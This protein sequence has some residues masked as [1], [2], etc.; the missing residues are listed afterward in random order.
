MAKIQLAFHNSSLN[1]DED[2]KVELTGML[3][4]ASDFIKSGKVK[5]AE[6]LS[7]FSK[8]LFTIFLSQTK[9]GQYIAINPFSNEVVKMQ[10][11]ELPSLS[12]LR[13]FTSI[14][15]NLDLN[16][17]HTKLMELKASQTDLIGAYTD[18]QMEMISKLLAAPRDNRSDFT[19]LVPLRG[20]GKIKADVKSVN[21]KI[22]DEASL[23]K[24]VTQRLDLIETALNDDSTQYT[25][26]LTERTDYWQLEIR[27]KNENLDKQ[28]RERD[29][30]LEQQLADLTGK[31]KAKSEDNFEKFLLGVAKNIRRDETP[32]EGTLQKIEKLTGRSAQPEDVP[33]IDR[34][35]QQLADQ[36]ETFKAAVLFAK[37]Q[38]KNMQSKEYDISEMQELNVEGLKKV[39]EREKNEYREKANMIEKE[40]DPELEQLKK[41]RDESS[42]RLSKFRDLRGQWASEMTNSLETKGKQMISSSSLGLPSP[43]PLVELQIPIYLFQYKKKDELYTVVVPPVNL[44]D[45]FKKADRSAFAGNKKTVFYYLVVE[46]TKKQIA[47]WFEDAASSR[48]LQT[49]IARLPNILDDPSEL[50]DTFFNSQT[51]MTDKLK[52]NKK[53]I[54]KANERLTEVLTSG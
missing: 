15:K 49:I 35:L 17:L 26:K 12:D 50:R 7:R 27:N 11:M 53:D 14:H 10:I 18:K 40:R 47:N 51:L 25:N 48:D 16:R 38:V 42:D 23:K 28:L 36:A 41:E 4:L 37:R 30:Q 45:N 24:A 13:E 19:P 29:A 44:P 22:Y 21:K 54:K 39:S 2:K 46:E 20:I 9:S 31:T 3:I 43:D 1:E 6:I 34:L 33:K 32:L 5:G 8:A 52:A